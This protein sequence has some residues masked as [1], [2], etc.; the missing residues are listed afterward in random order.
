MVVGRDDEGEKE[1]GFLVS[2]WNASLRRRQST[3]MRNDRSGRFNT[4]HVGH[5]T[6][7][8]KIVGFGSY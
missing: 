4:A 1:N 5:A 7:T 2:K 8:L 6:T 3:T